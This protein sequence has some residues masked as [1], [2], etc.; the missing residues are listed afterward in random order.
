MGRLRRRVQ[1]D[2][3]SY[4]TKHVSDIK[5]AAV[6]VVEAAEHV[7]TVMDKGFNDGASF[8][9]EF[10]NYN[11]TADTRDFTRNLYFGMVGN[12]DCSCSQEN[13]QGVDNAIAAAEELV[14]KLKA[15]KKTYVKCGDEYAKLDHEGFFNDMYPGKE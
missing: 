8:V 12:S 13:L 3:K 14:A 5:R 4:L 15:F 10:L 2:A 11:L 6:E 9:D 1:A 7:T